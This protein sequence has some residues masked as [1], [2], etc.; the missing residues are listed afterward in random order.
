LRVAG[1]QVAPEVHQADA[2]EREQGL[3]P[4]V[5]AIACGDWMT[6]AA[7]IHTVDME[8]SSPAQ[9][10][11]EPTGMLSSRRSKGDHD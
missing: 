5:A 11:G 3:L 6:A 8:G 9:A 1:L 4:P 10:P 2:D 7:E